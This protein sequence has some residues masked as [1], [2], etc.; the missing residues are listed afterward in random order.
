M[1]YVSMSYHRLFFLENCPKRQNS[2]DLCV[3]RKIQCLAAAQIAQLALKIQDPLCKF[4][5]D[6]E[7]KILAKILLVQI[8]LPR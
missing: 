8:I 3:F 4:H 2:H 7:D 1:L 5:L 6:S